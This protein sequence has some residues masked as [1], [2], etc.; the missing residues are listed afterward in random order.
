MESWVTS[1]YVKLFIFI[2]VFFCDAVVFLP[3]PAAPSKAAILVSTCLPAP[4][5]G[6]EL[7]SYAPVLHEFF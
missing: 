5:G 4:K 2:T 6:F 3:H 1:L 7:L